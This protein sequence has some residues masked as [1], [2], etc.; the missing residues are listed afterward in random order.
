MNVCSSL[1][2]F[3]T[4]LHLF[5]TTTSAHKPPTHSKNHSTPTNISRH[6]INTQ[7]SITES[8]HE[9]EEKKVPDMPSFASNSVI[10][11]TYRQFQ[12]RDFH[13]P[14]SNA[15]A[16]G[17]CF[18]LGFILA[19][20]MFTVVAVPHILRHGELRW[21]RWRR[22]VWIYVEEVPSPLEQGRR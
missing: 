15:E 6:A 20:C 18:L 16:I 21:L 11:S 2:G 8:Y 19:L 17:I 4:L 13:H 7:A 12:P 5:S 1:D 9:T 3:P 14:S 22:L 10:A